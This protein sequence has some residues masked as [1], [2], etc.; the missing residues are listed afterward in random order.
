MEIAAISI[1]E[2]NFIIIN[3]LKWEQK[4]FLRLMGS[5]YFKK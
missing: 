3:I 5:I 1:V 2:I 4:N